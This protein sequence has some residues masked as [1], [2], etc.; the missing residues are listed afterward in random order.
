MSDIDRLRDAMAEPPAQ[1]FAPVDIERVMRLGGR[2]PGPRCQLN[3]GPRVS[4]LGGVAGP[5][6]GVQILRKPPVPAS[7]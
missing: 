1:P 2:R 3:P 7:L 6:V 5:G 4:A